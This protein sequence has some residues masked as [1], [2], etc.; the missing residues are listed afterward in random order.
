M[1]DPNVFTEDFFKQRAQVKQ[2]ESSLVSSE[3]QIPDVDENLNVKE[4]Q[5]VEK[6]KPEIFKSLKDRGSVAA[7]LGLINAA[8]GTSKVDALELSRD[9]SVIG[10]QTLGGI[11]GGLPGAVGGATIGE[12]NAQLN[13]MVFGERTNFD[14][15]DIASESITTAAVEGI[16]RLPAKVAFGRLKN[17]D[18]LVKNNKI[19]SKT[20]DALDEMGAKFRSSDLIKEIDSFGKNVLDQRGVVGQTLRSWKKILSN[21]DEISFR[22]L[23]QFKQR[24]QEASNFVSEKVPKNTEMD[25]VARKLADSINVKL[26]KTASKFG[27]KNWGTINKK[28]ADLFN[29]IGKNS[30]RLRTMISSGAVGAAVGGLTRSGIGTAAGI[31]AAETLTSPGVRQSLFEI[32]KNPLAKLLSTGARI[33]TSEGVRRLDDA[34]NITRSTF[35]GVGVTEKDIKDF[36]SSG[37]L[38]STVEVGSKLAKEK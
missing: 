33:G 16:F 9:V 8:G 13:E 22:Q 5:P 7:Q 31:A 6:T 18:E 30:G 26:E 21:T 17:I 4:S 20:A 24:L 3:A 27:V 23:R 29:K 14:L 35:R 25:R 32:S 15:T 1:A 28:T 2:Q 11:Y 34:T 12:L 19:I 36:I 10:L 37:K 38:A